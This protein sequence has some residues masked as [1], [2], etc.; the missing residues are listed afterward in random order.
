MRGGSFGGLLKEVMGI[1]TTHTMNGLLNEIKIVL[2]KRMRKEKKS[3]L[4]QFVE[5]MY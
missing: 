5:A 2:K 4:I 1:L 3:V